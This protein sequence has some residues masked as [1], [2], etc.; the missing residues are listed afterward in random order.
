MLP[1]EEQEQCVSLPI[2]AMG[3][4]KGFNMIFLIRSDE[5]CFGTLNAD[6][7]ALERLQMVRGR[8]SPYFGSKYR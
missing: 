1:G 5:A 3:M 7:N 4:R 6:V 2:T 8:N